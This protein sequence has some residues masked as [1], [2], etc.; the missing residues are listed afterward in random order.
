MTDAAFRVLVEHA[1]D[2]IVV[3]DAAAVVRYV[4]PS[5]GRLGYA[6]D[7]TGKPC[8][9]II[10]PADRAA[11]ADA[12][13][14]GAPVECRLPLAGG[15][16]RT[17]EAV[18]TDL[19]DEPAVAGLMIDFRDVSARKQAEEQLHALNT[20]LERQIAA[21]A[22][23]EKLRSV[24][25][26]IPG[27]VYRMRA[28][29][30][31]RDVVHE[32]VS[33]GARGI[34]G[35]E[36]DEILRDSAA[37]INRIN[38]DDMP[39]ME[40]ALRAAIETA[41]PVD[42]EYRVRHKDGSTRWIRGRVRVSGRTPDGWVVFDG[43]SL[44]ITAQKETERQLR[45]NDAKFRALF[46]GTSA[47]VVL[48]DPAT[49]SLLDCNQALLDTLRCAREDAIGQ[50]TVRFAAPIQAGGLSPEE[51]RDRKKAEVLAG[52]GHRQ[53]ILVHRPD[54]TEFPAEFVLNPFHLDGRQV[55]LGIL[56][57]IS[58][59][60]RVEEA[61]RQAA[62]AAE[63]ASRAKTEFLAHMSHEIRTPMN[64][65]L[66]LTELALDTDLKPDQRE[67]LELV[68][69]SADALLTILNDLLDLSKIEAGKL[70]LERTPFALRR[71]LA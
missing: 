70:D 24:I 9:E 23:A 10:H 60:K 41:V 19:R 34:V 28:H 31:T 22:A 5:A 14:K 4:S 67:Y 27:V 26:S 69:S 44:D 2:L 38:P 64:G 8:A 61:L 45:E 66:G 15:G 29:L 55:V 59:R 13:R 49:N 54:G 7:W 63:A 39:S 42:V 58:E 51:M 3:V 36:P 68:R 20:E 57:D 18:V 46:E 33:D 17:V 52:T 65:I 6:S 12:M 50:Q 62:Q 1:A 32:F 56:T 21:G 43:F 11:F 48:I 35:L 71:Q 25:A 30:V 47:G 37:F 53:E 16:W 40:S